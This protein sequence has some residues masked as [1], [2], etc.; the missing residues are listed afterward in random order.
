MLHPLDFRDNNQLVI[1]R[2]I[3]SLATQSSQSRAGKIG[4]LNTPACLLGRN[5]YNEATFTKTGL[6]LIEMT[7]TL[8]DIVARNSTRPDA[9]RVSYGCV[10]GAVDPA[11]PPSMNGRAQP[12]ATPSRQQPTRQREHAGAS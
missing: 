11:P 3:E 5:V 7:K 2:G 10:A 12:S 9:V 1:D 6:T 8:Q 4:L